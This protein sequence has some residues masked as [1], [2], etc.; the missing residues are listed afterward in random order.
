MSRSQTEDTSAKLGQQSNAVK[1]HKQSLKRNL[2]NSAVKSLI[3]TYI[4]KLLALVQAKDYKASLET[5][6]KVQSALFKGAKKK[7]SSSSIKRLE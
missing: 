2:R 3:K 7:M 5:F 4:K 6:A 1:A